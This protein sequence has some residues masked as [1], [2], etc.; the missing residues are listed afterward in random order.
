MTGRPIA[1]RLAK[2]DD[3]ISRRLNAFAALSETDLDV[4][5]RLRERR[6]RHRVGEELF[7][8]GE[9]VRRPRFIVSGWA[10]SQRVLS[11]G[12]RQIFSFSLPGDGLGLYPRMT[13]PALYTVV[14]ATAMETVDAQ[15]V[16]EL[17]RSGRS[18][19][20][21][22]A[23]AAAARAE[24]IEFLDHLTRLGR[25]TAYERVAHFLLEIHD[26]LAVV[27]LGTE[28]HFP[29]PLTQEILAD[30][31]GLSIVHVNRTLQQLRR[32]KLIE[33][34]SGVAVLLQRETLAKVA[35]YR[36]G[37]RPGRSTSA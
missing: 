1:Q 34:R 35:D 3:V 22:R 37:S 30:A 15:P 7:V 2:A 13:P 24:D 10:S 19:G 21:L 32:D 25:Q 14:A 33:W 8:E 12:R 27:G 20:L 6:D 36:L 31:L 17:V 9:A 5:A 26:R 18:P 29:L 16:L 28:R 4:V 11:D 23:F